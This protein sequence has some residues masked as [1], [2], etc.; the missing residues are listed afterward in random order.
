MRFWGERV[1][2]WLMDKMAADDEELKALRTRALAPTGGR[3]LE[4]G[5]GTGLNLY[6]Y[7]SG[8]RRIVAVDPNPGM[9]ERARERM[10]SLGIDVEH[11]RITAET[12]PFDASSFDSVVCTLTLCSI[13]RVD[14]ALGEVRRVLKPGGQF[15]FLEHG[16]HPDPG[17]S[18]WQ[19]RLNGVWGKLF[20]GCNINRDMPR[21][22]ADSGL[23]TT[24]LDNQALTKMPRPVGYFFLGRAEKTV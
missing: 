13:P 14:Q 3:V 5:F 23:V 19:D 10:A 21:L 1:F 12:L 20:D 16:R 18:R 2:P 11:H 6:H 24:A 9:K 15:L 8:I 22:I 17:V 4:L 7:P